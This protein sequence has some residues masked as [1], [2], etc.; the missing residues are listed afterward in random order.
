MRE[1]QLTILE[2]E[3]C[4][5]LHE[6]Q[7]KFVSPKQ[8]S[9]AVI[10]AGYGYDTNCQGDAGLMQ[11]VFDQKTRSYPFYQTGILSYGLGCTPTEIPAV[12]A[13]VQHFVDWI[14]EKISH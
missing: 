3:K 12:Y 8:F 5:E 10:C 1:S 9:E 6:K 14:Q 7:G 13:R 4:K 2:N 11:P